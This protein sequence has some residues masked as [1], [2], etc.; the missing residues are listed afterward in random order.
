MHF[1]AHLCE[2]LLEG[3]AFLSALPVVTLEKDVEGLLLPGFKLVGG[4][5]DVH[6]VHVVDVADDGGTLLDGDDGAAALSDFED[7][8][9]HNASNQVVA[10]LL[11]LTENLKVTVVEEVVGTC[12]VANNHEGFLVVGSG[13]GRSGALRGVGG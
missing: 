8:V 10:V 1:H 13:D 11:S 7:V 5:F 3:A 9:V 2:A 12:G 4:G 6:L